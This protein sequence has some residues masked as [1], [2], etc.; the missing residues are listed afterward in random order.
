MVFIKK[1]LAVGLVAAFMALA[2]AACGGNNPTSGGQTPAIS[3]SAPPEGTPKESIPVETD[4]TTEPPGT[5][6][7]QITFGETVLTATMLDNETAR[8]FLSLLPLTFTLSDY[9]GTEK[10]GDPPRSLSAKGAPEGY[11]PSAGD[12]TIYAPWGN[13]AIFYKDFRYSNGLIPLGH[14]DSGI[15]ELEKMEGDFSATIELVD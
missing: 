14:I 13:L 2:L 4:S 7:L 6:K 9:G 15:E 8:D 11:E 3:P 1:L 10:I 12:V 5:V